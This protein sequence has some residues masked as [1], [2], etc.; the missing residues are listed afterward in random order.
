MTPDTTAYMIAGFIVIL[1][2]I[3]IYIISILLRYNQARHQAEIFNN[4]GENQSREIS[5]NT[6]DQREN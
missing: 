6:K 1:G 4:I 5:D 3:F 2:G